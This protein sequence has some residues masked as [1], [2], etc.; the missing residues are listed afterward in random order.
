M[1]KIFA[2]SAI[3]IAAM[4]TLS[5]KGGNKAAEGEA[6]EGAEVTEQGCCCE[7]GV[8]TPEAAAEAAEV[9]NPDELVKIDDADAAAMTAAGELA[10]KGVFE[11]VAVEVKP[12]FNGGDVSDFTDWV[13]ANINY[14]EVAKEN[15]QEGKVMVS[16]I[17][18]TDGK[19]GDVKTISSVSPALDAEAVRVVESSPA[20]TPA[21]QDGQAVP[22]HYTMPIVFKLQ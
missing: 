5:C 6:A 19:V 18:G 15:N 7:G 12:E 2:I 21:R 3:V 20:W 16:F 17:V 4:L 10:A 1:K 8:C 22:V 13:Y 11:A 9:Q 14:P